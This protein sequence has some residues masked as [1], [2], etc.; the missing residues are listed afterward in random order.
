MVLS[1][2]AGAGQRP[3]TE[4]PHGDHRWKVLLIDD[5]E[6]ALEVAQGVLEASGF[7]VRATTALDHFDEILMDW[8][9]EV[10]LTDVNMP[11]MT[12]VELCSALKRRYET[13]HVPI[14]LCSSLPTRELA[15]LA[16]KCDADGYVS[17][18]ERL[19]TLAEELR[20]LCETIAW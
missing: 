13:A 6:I 20:A 11:G 7:E 15:E 8:S 3:R 9:P 12:G 10:I 4:P 18:S 17:K 1:E 19:E 14:L 16:R 5:S 2:R